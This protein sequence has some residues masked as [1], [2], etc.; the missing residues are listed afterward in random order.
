ML[1]AKTLHAE[2]SVYASIKCVAME[3]H[4]GGLRIY[5]NARNKPTEV[6]VSESH[7]APPCLLLGCD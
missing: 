7:G 3:A 6:S 5:K 2:H 4:E 1:P